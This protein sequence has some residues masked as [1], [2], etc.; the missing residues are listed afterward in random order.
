[1]SSAFFLE[2]PGVAISSSSVASSKKLSIT[3]LPESPSSCIENILSFFFVHL[4][5]EH[6]YKSTIG[7]IVLV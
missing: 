1:M 2:H 5:K 4:L 3:F 6:K 7:R